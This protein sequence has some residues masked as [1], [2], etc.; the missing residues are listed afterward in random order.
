MIGVLAVRPRS[1]P[2]LEV[3]L[4]RLLAGIADQTALIMEHFELT[5]TMEATRNS[6]R[7]REL[8]SMLL[9]SA[10]HDLKTPLAGIIG[11]LSVHR[12]L[13]TK[14]PPEKRAELLDDALEEAQRLD[15][16]ITNILDITRLESGKVEFRPDWFEMQGVIL[17][18]IKRMNHRLK[19][20]KITV[21]PGGE[22]LEVYMDGMLGEQILQ[23]LIDNACKYTPPGTISPSPARCVRGRASAVRS[24]ILAM[25]FRQKNSPPYS[26]NMRVSKK[27]IRKLPAPAW[28]YPS[29]RPCWKRKAGGSRPRITPKA[30]RYLPSVTP[31]GGV[32]RTDDSLSEEVA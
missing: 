11:S 17:H 23:N 22:N 24:V 4:S 7:T 21:M 19:G 32:V 12:S 14:V 25:A 27:S 15:S 26:I 5:R 18:V 9:S 31:N 13:G 8:R 3:W 16:F 30:V 28:A 6:R 20:R 2:V 1:R 10:S 29:A